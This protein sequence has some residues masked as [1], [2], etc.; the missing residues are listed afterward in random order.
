[1]FDVGVLCADMQ[2]LQV[3]MI[4]RLARKRRKVPIC[5]KV[6]S[7]LKHVWKAFRIGKEFWF[8]FYFRYR[9]E[10]SFS[11]VVGY[12]SAYSRKITN[13][14][15]VSCWPLFILALLF[16]PLR[17]QDSSQTNTGINK[18]E[19]W[20]KYFLLCVSKYLFLFWK[21]G[22]KDLQ[23]NWVLV[24]LFHIRKILPVH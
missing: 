19:V 16:F 13:F 15:S 3:L 2:R 6:E 12:S 1:M 8:K 18:Q 10:L 21:N 17:K 14:D 7:L 22:V 4:I 5:V 20:Q 11:C 9:T 24:Y 23:F